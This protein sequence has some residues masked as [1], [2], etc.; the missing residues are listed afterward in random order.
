MVTRYDKYRP[1][2]IIAL[3]IFGKEFFQTLVKINKGCRF[4]YFIFHSLPNS[5]ILY[6]FGNQC[7]LF[8]IQLFV[9]HHKRL[10]GVERK[11]NRQV[12]QTVVEMLEGSVEDGAVFKTPTVMSG[13]FGHAPFLRIVAHYLLHAILYKVGIHVVEMSP[14]AVEKMRQ[15]IVHTHNGNKINKIRHILTQ[16]HKGSFASQRQRAQ[17]GG[18][19][20]KSSFARTQSVWPIKA[21]TRK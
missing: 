13:I 6:F 19:H 11:E 18:K 10:M 20:L 1:F 8:N 12:G 7:S 3:S 21:L 9:V 16:I 15:V 4:F 5:L 2:E 14:S 17:H